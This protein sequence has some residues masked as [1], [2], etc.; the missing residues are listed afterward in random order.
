[1]FLWALVSVGGTKV[2]SYAL[3]AALVREDFMAHKVTSHFLFSQACIH[4]GGALG[5]VALAIKQSRVTQWHT[6]LFLTSALHLHS[7]THEVQP[8]GR[9]IGI[10]PGLGG[11]GG[12]G[13]KRRYRTRECWFRS[14]QAV[15]NFVCW[16]VPK[17]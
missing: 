7:G 8:A 16:Q 3:R 15:L 10:V 4:Q 12:G 6:G 2:F 1:M 11:G 5:V 9:A 17:T 14:A 13:E